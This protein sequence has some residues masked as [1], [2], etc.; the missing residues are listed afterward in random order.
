[1]GHWNDMLKKNGIRPYRFVGEVAD[2]LLRMSEI[3]RNMDGERNRLIQENLELRA[4]IAERGLMFCRGKLVED[5][6]SNP[7]V[8]GSA[9]FYEVQDQRD[10]RHARAY[11]EEYNTRH[12]YRD[13]R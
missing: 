13:G 2:E 12:P 1:M 9:K 3:V 10:E 6:S 5:P 8:F 7:D 11:I 4:A